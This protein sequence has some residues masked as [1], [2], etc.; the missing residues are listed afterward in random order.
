MVCLLLFCSEVGSIDI[1]TAGHPGNFSFF[2]G[3]SN[4]VSFPLSDIGKPPECSRSDSPRAT[5]APQHAQ[6]RLCCRSRQASLRISLHNCPPR[7]GNRRIDIKPTIIANI[8]ILCTY[9]HIIAST[10]QSPTARSLLRNKSSKSFTTSSTQ[11]ATIFSLISR[12]WAMGSPAADNPG[13]E[14]PLLEPR[15]PSYS[16]P[17]NNE[18]PSHVPQRL[19]PRP[20][21]LDLPFLHTLRTSRVI[22]ASSS[23]RRQQILSHLSLPRLEIIPSAA[24]EDQPKTLTP[25]EY[26]LRTAT[27]KAITVYRQEINN[28]ARGEPRLILAADTVIADTQSGAAVILEK[29]VS[30][31]HHVAMLSRLRN[32]GEH[33]V[34]TAIVAMAPLASARDPGYAMESHVEETTVVF[35][36]RVTDELILAYVKTGE[37]AEKAG[38]YAVQGLGSILT[39]KIEGS[40]D[41]VIGLPLKETLRLMEKV[42]VKADD[43]DVYEADFEA[44]EKEDE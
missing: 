3:F 26:V 43:E 37:G 28:E 21:P 33:K 41:N 15:P 30:E 27:T 31:A 4:D 5:P 44:A 36:G 34:Y 13:S 12:F 29:P 24:A 42:L 7:L 11:T 16:E 2:R 39:E 35:D 6:L 38:G 20:P 40:Y 22:L 10:V 25:Y 18:P 23:P 1:P 9:V 19:P 8:N 32:A 17:T 14:E